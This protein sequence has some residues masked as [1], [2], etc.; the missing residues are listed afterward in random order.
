MK[1]ILEDF[2][3]WALT[4]LNIQRL[5]SITIDE[6]RVTI[7][8]SRYIKDDGKWHQFG[9]SVLF[10]IRIAKGTK[11]TYM[12][13]VTVFIDGKEAKKGKK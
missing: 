1:Q 8:I 6:S 9:A 7:G 3:V 11:P 10:N 4:K 2:L 5:K 13:D 12:E